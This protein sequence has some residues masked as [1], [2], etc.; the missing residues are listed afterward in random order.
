MK[1]RADLHIHSC[2]SPCGS[3]EMSPRR[4][5][6]EAFARSLDIVALTDHNSSL[7]TPTFFA[8]ASQYDFLPIAG[9]EITSREEIHILALFGSYLEA[10]DM[11][12]WI[13]RSLPPLHFS[14][15]K[16]G[17]QVYVDE[18]DRIIG[19]VEYY[20]GQ[21][22]T[23][24]IEE[25][26]KA[27]HERKGLAIPAHIDRRG[28]GLLDN[29]GFLSPPEETGF[30]AIELSH[31]YWLSP[32]SISSVDLYPCLVSSDAHYPEAIGSHVSIIDVKE[33]NWEGFCAALREHRIDI[34][35]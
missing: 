28:S 27:I 10:L 29:L 18:E 14:P 19:E 9:L 11:G 23:Y 22:S 34:E 3:L 6:E 12:E 33:K 31:H 17:D 7:N 13:Y 8:L 4:I 2:L 15:E 16:F 35:K 5:V 21:A 30:D 32:Y 26:V 20:L 25:I 24:S 1:L